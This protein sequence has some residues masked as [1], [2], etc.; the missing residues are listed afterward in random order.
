MLETLERIIGMPVAREKEC[1]VAVFHV[2]HDRSQ[3]RRG[4]FGAVTKFVSRK[5]WLDQRFNIILQRLVIFLRFLAQLLH[6]LLVLPQPL[7]PF[8]TEDFDIMLEWCN[9]LD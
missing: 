6:Y 3:I 7:V 1:F 4:D 5:S 8:V 2:H 9:D